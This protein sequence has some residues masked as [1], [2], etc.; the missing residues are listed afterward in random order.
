MRGTGKGMSLLPL[1]PP[2]VLGLA[3]HGPFAEFKVEGTVWAMDEGRALLRHYVDLLT[4]HTPEA[5][6]ALVELHIAVGEAGLKRHTPMD[7]PIACK[8]GCS[9]CCHQ[10]VSVSALEIF[11]IAR[12]LRHS[13]DC[14]SHIQ[15]LDAK[16][17]NTNWD[18]SRDFDV[19]NPCAFLV[20]GACNIHPVR[21]MICRIVVSLD[22]NACISQL[23]KGSGETP[24]PR[25]IVAMRGWLNPAI[26]AALQ[27]AELPVREY[28]LTAAVRAVVADPSIEERWY[29]G[30]D[31]L[32]PFSSAEE[33]PDT[34]MLDEIA[35]WR[36]MANV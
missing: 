10:H 18:R 1:T 12:R 6:D 35:Q 4:R 24:H 33:T 5:G 23:M 8:M 27:A 16:L 28:E 11:Y 34:I 2:I 32:A 9:H 22:V 20:D 26:Y 14:A 3:D 15:R 17:A 25:A 19:R 30:D 31:A 13:A 7:A 21:P 29:R 36:A